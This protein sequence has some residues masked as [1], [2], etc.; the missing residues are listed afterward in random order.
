MNGFNQTT[1]EA[2]EEIVFGPVTSTKTTSFSGGAGP[3]QDSISS[4]SGRTVGVTNR[5]VVI[6]DMQSPEKSKII[7]N[8]QVQRVSIKRKQKGGQ[9]TITIS[10]VETASG[11]AVKVDLPGISARQEPRLNEIFPNAEIG[12]AK[13]LSKGLI[14]A[15]AVVGGLIVICCLITVVGPLIGQLFAK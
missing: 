11:A 8:D 6:E 13:G 15:L 1:L 4:T 2:G 10:K 5:R 3:S 9:E 12:A 7:P 14:I